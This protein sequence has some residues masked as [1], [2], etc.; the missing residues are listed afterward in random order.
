MRNKNN[1]VLR[2]LKPSWWKILLT[3]TATIVSYLFVGMKT[4][5]IFGIGGSTKCLPI[6]QIGIE[7]DFLI[8]GLS[9]VL[10]YFLF[11]FIGLLIGRAKNGKRK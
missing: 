9:I 8:V 6:F 4:E 1:S 7:N 10:F 11:S 2:F 3:V 5:C